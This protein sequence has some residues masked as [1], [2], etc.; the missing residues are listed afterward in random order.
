M[1]ILD[2]CV[3]GASM[4]EVRRRYLWHT[5]WQSPEQPGGAEPGNLAV[6]AALMAR[7]SIARFV[8]GCVRDAL[9]GRTVKD[10]DIATPDPPAQVMD[11]LRAASI[12]AIPTGVDHGTVTA[13]VNGT[14]TRVCRSLPRGSNVGCGARWIRR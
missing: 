13:V 7:G 5:G 6:I 12:K 8:G 1:G 11:L 3:N 10:I 14:C 2:R 4:E 9:S